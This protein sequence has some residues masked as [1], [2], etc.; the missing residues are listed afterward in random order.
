MDNADPPPTESSGFLV[1]P[2]K[3]PPTAIAT[4]DPPP[5]REPSPDRYR[6]LR[7]PRFIER[8]LDEVDKVADAIGSALGLRD[9]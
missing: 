6:T 9:R 1:P 2:T 7:T 5:P 4:A 3:L 8:W